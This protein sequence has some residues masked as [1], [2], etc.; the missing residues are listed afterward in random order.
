[1]LI[2]KVLQPIWLETHHTDTVRKYRIRGFGASPK[3]HTF[4]R[5]IEGESADTAERQSVYDYFREKYNVT[6]KHP[7]LPTV[8]KSIDR[9]AISFEIFL[10][11]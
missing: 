4:P 5:L 11:V 3:Q 6:L 10:I 9:N 1:M 2:R 7:H 8:G